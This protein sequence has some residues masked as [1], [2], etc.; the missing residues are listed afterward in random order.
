MIPKISVLVFTYNH[1][2]F[3]GQALESVLNQKVDFDYEIIV[4][5]DFSTDKTFNIISEFSAKFPEKFI[6]LEPKK[7]GI[8]ANSF[9]V[10][11]FVRGN[12]VAL[13]DGDD[14]WDYEFK[15][16]KQVDFLDQN[17]DFNGVFHDSKILNDGL[18][19]IDLF[20]GK[21]QYS[22]AFDYRKVIFPSDLIRR[23]IL[24]TGSAV[25]RTKALLNIDLNK[26]LDYY[27]LDWKT[28]CFAIRESKFYYINETWSVYRNHKHGV[29]KMERSKYA[30]SQIKFLKVLLRDDFYKN[31]KFEIYSSISNELLMLILA[32]NK[33]N[34]LNK[35][36]LFLK[37][38]VSEIKRIYFLRK[39]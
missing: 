12:Y 23:L 17:K 16:Q 29:S 34:G 26:F 6:V 31:Y 18:N 1:E 25:I 11:D 5:D 10:L 37:Y 2:D 3:I 21:K 9:R 14:Y 15:L 24:P 4:S 39:Y 33:I 20:D 7:S 30:L 27:S 19:V 38:I 28:Y 36:I 8:L 22:Q 13:L 32:N 35:K